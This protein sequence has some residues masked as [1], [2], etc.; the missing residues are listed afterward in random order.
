MLNPA[1]VGLDEED[2]SKLSREQLVV[3]LQSADVQREEMA[4]RLRESQER[5]ALLTGTTMDGVVVS[6][7]GR[8]Q[9]CNEQFAQIAGRSVEELRGMTIAQLMA[10][11]DIDRSH[12]VTH[13]RRGNNGEYAILRGDGLSVPVALSGHPIGGD[14][15]RE[16]HLVIVRDLS[17]QRRRERKLQQLNRTLRAI[18]HSGHALLRARDESAFLTEACH[19]VVEDC[20]HRMAWIGYAE[21]D[22]SICPVA[23]AGHE[24]GY[25]RDAQFNWADDDEGHGPTGTAIRARTVS[26]C[27]DTR[28]DPHFAPWR[29]MAE[30]RGYRSVIAFPMLSGGKAFG[31]LVVYAEEPDA[32]SD[33]EIALLNELAD[34]V[35]FGIQTLRLRRAHAQTEAALRV[36]QADLNR[37]Q[38]VGHIG[39]W[40]LDIRLNKLTWS[41]EN[42]RIFAI[43]EGTE[44]TYQTFLARIHP[45]DREYVDRKWQAALR[46]ER[47]DIEHRI[48]FDDRVKW[49]RERA[50]LEFDRNGVLLGGFGTCQ[51]VTERKSAEEALR[52]SETHYRLLVE[53]TM[54]GIL[55]HDEHGGVVDI[56]SEGARMHGYTREEFLRLNVADLIAPEDARHLALELARHGEGGVTRTEWRARRKDGS[57]FFVEAVVLKLSGGLSQVVIRDVTERKQSET[58]RLAELEKQRDALVREVHHRI[59]NHLQGVIALMRNRSMAMPELSLP[60][61]EAIGQIDTIAQVYGLQC[62]RDDSQV[63]LGSLVD[64]AVNSASGPIAIEYRPPVDRETHCLEANEI[65]PVALVVNELL[66]NAIKHTRDQ[67]GAVQVALTDAGPRSS[68]RFSNSPASLRDD[69]NFAAGSGLGTGLELVRGLLPPKGA[70]LSFRQEASQVIVELTLSPP[71]LLPLQ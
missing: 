61:G 46:G 19:N 14:P 21:D 49:V 53:Q 17:R 26:L 28:T 8:I 70:A 48:L 57:L 25:L 35:A 50:E 44:L 33:Q 18:Q 59:K 29:D 27:R 36:S 38:A 68:I 20:G 63:T 37:A 31:V 34:D 7:G 52:R 66:T 22:Y 55:V 5:L 54:D 62:K 42:H 65:V 30:A 1:S 9:D 56:N 51:D 58:R 67:S 32:Y 24:D 4:T 13:S 15:E 64:I 60:L 71:V 39:S 10:P 41:A 45:D 43:S 3:R 16:Q 69:F 11:E 40:R 23:W 2:L 6:E 12:E 47:F